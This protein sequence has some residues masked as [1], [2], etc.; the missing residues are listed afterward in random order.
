[1][2]KKSLL[3]LLIIALVLS[4]LCAVEK[5]DIVGLWYMPAN[6]AGEIAVA[7]IFK[8]NDKYYAVAFAYKSYEKGDTVLPTKDINNP[9]PSVRDKTLDEVIIVND[10]SFNGKKWVDGEIY[11]PSVGKYYYL[12]GVLKNNGTKLA[13]KATV[14]RLGLFGPSL[15][16]TKVENLDFYAPLRKTQAELTEMIPNKR[17]K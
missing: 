3:I 16:W 12:S 8:E 10:I 15:E 14:D 9:D 17:Y 13:W 11:N 7:E 4:A 1:M 5:D 6:D 2:I